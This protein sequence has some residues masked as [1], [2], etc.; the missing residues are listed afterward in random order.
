MRHNHFHDNPNPINPYALVAAN[1]LYNA[2][3]GPLWSEMGH[4]VYQDARHYWQ[5]IPERVRDFAAVGRWFRHRST[6]EVFNDISRTAQR[7]LA[8]YRQY[9]YYSKGKDFAREKAAKAE[10]KLAGLNHKRMFVDRRIQLRYKRGYVGP[11]T[12]RWLRAYNK[13]H[14]RTAPR[15]GRRRYRK[16][17]K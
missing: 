6:S 16:K 12:A 14:N 10:A 11:K 13:K 17:F 15:F 2:A 9:A 1:A 5:S 7:T 8:G 4:R 3:D